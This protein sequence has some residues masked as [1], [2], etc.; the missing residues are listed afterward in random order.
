MVEVIFHI[1]MGKTGTSSIQACLFENRQTLLKDF[2]VDYM[3]MGFEIISSDFSGPQGNAAFLT[4]QNNEIRAQADIFHASAI[5]RAEGG[6]IRFMISNE[7]IYG[8]PDNFSQFCNRLAEQCVVKLICYARN[9]YEW[10]P[11]AYI[12]WAVFHKANKGPVISFEDYAR[13]HIK[14]YAAL[15]R[16]KTLSTGYQFHL[17][18]HTKDV[19][20]VDDFAKICGIELKRR[21]HRA[22][23]R[24]DPVEVVFRGAFN[25]HFVEEV[26]PYEFD[27]AFGENFS[28]KKFSLAVFLCRSLDYSPTDLIVKEARPIFE[29]IKD[30]LGVDL[31]TKTLP[32][33][34]PDIEELREKIVD[35]LIHQMTWQARTLKAFEDRIRRLEATVR[36]LQESR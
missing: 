32:N 7:A 19:D 13:Q 15:V 34:L 23:E 5:K 29:N 16:W 25:G 14:S 1:G 11:S 21:P 18:P 30:E 8:Y 26:L 31:V 35:V 12:Q 36:D 9:P 24:I 33:T 28:K 17:R 2:Q 6:A 10:L 27:A 20:V 4:L 22:L 3:G